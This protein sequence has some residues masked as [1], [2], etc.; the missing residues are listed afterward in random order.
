MDEEL[1]GTVDHGIGSFLMTDPDLP[2]DE[3]S[4]P[5]QPLFYFHGDRI[6][7]LVYDQ[8]GHV[9]AYRNTPEGDPRVEESTWQR[10]PDP[11]AAAAVEWWEESKRSH[12]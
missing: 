9:M 4:W 1:D 7:G 5:Y 2:R 12:G 3:F 8:D 6:T 10:A 11:V